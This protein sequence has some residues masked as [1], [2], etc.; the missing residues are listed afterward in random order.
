MHMIISWAMHYVSLLHYN[1]TTFKLFT[2]GTYVLRIFAFQ[3]FS[4]HNFTAELNTSM[5]KLPY[6]TAVNCNK[7]WMSWTALFNFKSYLTISRQVIACSL[8]FLTQ[9]LYHNSLG[10]YTENFLELMLVATYIDGI[11]SNVSHA[12]HNHNYLNHHKY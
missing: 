5:H 12:E 8:I 3:I 2:P 1:M 10:N 11:T 9:V 6:N 7:S 4:S